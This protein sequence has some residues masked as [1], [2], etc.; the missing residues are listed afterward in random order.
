MRRLLA[1][2]CAIICCVSG[3]QPVFLMTGRHTDQSSV[4]SKMFGDPES[5]WYQDILTNTAFS[6]TQA[7]FNSAEVDLHAIATDYKSQR[8]YIFDPVQPFIRYM[9]VS[10]DES[11]KTTTLFRLSIPVSRKL[12]MHQKDVV[13][14][15]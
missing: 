4:L 12:C 14:G 9:N 8:A 7:S 11:G 1:I 6:A 13:I 3:Q 15:R 5:T 2:L 10:L